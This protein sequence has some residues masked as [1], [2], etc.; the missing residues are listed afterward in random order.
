[1]EST[2][3]WVAETI[4]DGKAEY[5]SFIDIV[6]GKLK[7][8][9]TE[10]VSKA[11]KYKAKFRADDDSQYVNAQLRNK[12]GSKVLKELFGDRRLHSRLLTPEEAAE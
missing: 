5:I 7:V 8:E 4:K 10:D 12:Q 9:L 2:K 1:M 11:V 6:G 3:R